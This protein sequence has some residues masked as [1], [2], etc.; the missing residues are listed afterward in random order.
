MQLE[1]KD[2]VK[3]VMIVGGHELK[4]TT[5]D[6]CGLTGASIPWG[7]EAEIFIIAIIGGRKFFC[8]LGEKYIVEHQW[9]G[10]VFRGKFKNFREKEGGNV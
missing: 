3:V 6:W 1:E 7:N 4:K 5:V 9:L 2:I 8:I 10:D